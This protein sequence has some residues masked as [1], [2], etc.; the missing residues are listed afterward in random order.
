MPNV[1]ARDRLI[2]SLNG[3]VYGEHV[4]A[5]P[6][7]N[8]PGLTTYLLKEATP[9]AQYRKGFR[10]I[11]GSIPLGALG[12]DRVVLSNDLKE[13]LLRS[14]RI[15][16]YRRTYAKRQKTVSTQPGTQPVEP[17]SLELSR[18]A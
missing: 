12:G 13:A 15:E 16:P 11:K 7:V 10:R 2:E 18:A 17:V 5:R 1:T 8:W 9:Q 3:S 14:G 6:V 4:D